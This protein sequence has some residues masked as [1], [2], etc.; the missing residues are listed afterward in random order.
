MK[1]IKAY[2]ISLV[3]IFAMLS[4][5]GQ[6]S[7]SEWTKGITKA[8][9]HY[10]QGKYFQAIRSVKKLHRYQK[11]KGYLPHLIPVTA[12]LKAKYENAYGDAQSAAET[13]E[14]VEEN[15]RLSES[16]ADSSV[17]I[18]ANAYLADVFLSMDYTSKAT[19]YLDKV[20]SLLAASPQPNRLL[21][22]QLRYK[23]LE[24]LITRHDLNEALELYKEVLKEQQAIS[25]REQKIYHPETGENETKKLKKREY[26]TRRALI[27][28]LKAHEAEMYLM[29]GDYLTA[30]SL[31][32]NLEFVINELVKRKHESQVRLTVSKAHVLEYL[33]EYKEA[34]KGYKKGKKKYAG[35]LKTSVPNVFYTA[36]AEREINA[37]LK[38]GKERAAKKAIN[39]FSREHLKRYGRNNTYFLETKR[40]KNKDEIAN[41]NFAK[42]L[43]RAN[44]SVEDFSKFYPNIHAGKIPMLEQYKTL[45][46]KNNNYTLA[47]AVNNQILTILDSLHGDSANIYLENALDLAKLQTYFSYNFKSADS[48][49]NRAFMPI[50]Y[51]NLHPYHEKYMEHMES[52]ATLLIELDRFDSA[53]VIVNKT[54]KIVKAKYGITS[55]EYAKQLKL[56]A[57]IYILKGDFREAEETL[58][59]AVE[60][61][62]DDKA[63]Q[64]YVYY[65]A[66]ITLGDIQQ[67]NGKYGESQNTFKEAMR[68]GKRL[69]LNTDLLAAASSTEMAE[70]LVE[71]GRYKEAEE[72]LSKNIALLTAKHD[73]NYFQLVEP[74]AALG[75]LQLINGNFIEAEKSVSNALRIA[76]LNVSDTGS[77][78]IRNEIL[79]G[80]IYFNMGDYERANNTYRSALDK[81]ISTFGGNHIVTGDILI[82]QASVMLATKV[83][84]DTIVVVLEH[85][86]E[87]I[88]SAV[89]E[90]H[91]KYA[92]AIELQAEVLL[93]NKQYEP[94]LIL[95]EQA[96]AIYVRIYGTYHVRTVENRVRLGNLYFKQKIYP[97]AEENYLLALKAFKKIFGDQHPDYTA[98]L[99]KLG[100]CY[101]ASGD[102]KSAMNTFDVTT[103]IYLEY[104]SKYFPSLTE[105]EKAKY[106]NKI[107]TDFEIFNSL[108]VTYHHEKPKL[109][110][111]MYNYK[112]ATKALL[113]NSSMKVRKQIMASQD[114]GLMNLYN[115]WRVKREQ[116]GASLSLSFDEQDMSGI[117]PGVLEK[118]IA[119]LEK[120]LGERSSAFA[121]NTKTTLY[122][123]KDVKNTLKDNEAA[124]EIIRFHYYENAF[125]D[126]VV[127]AALVVTNETKKNPEL[128]IIPGGNELEEKYFKYYRNVIKYRAKDKYSYAR[129]WQPIEKALNNRSTIYLSADGVYNQLN[130]ETFRKHDNTFLIDKY[131][132]Y[133]VSN[134]K[135]LV[136]K[137]EST[138]QPYLTKTVAIFGNPE[139]GSIH[140]S[141]LEAS[142]TNSNRISSV[143]PLPGAE[144]EV[145]SLR[146]ILNENKWQ[147]QTYLSS[148]ATETEVKTVNNPRVI[149][150]ATHGFFVEEDAIAD[151][152]T[153]SENMPVDNPLL[154]SG[155]LFVGANELLAENN[156]FRVN[157]KEGILTAY[158]AMNLSLDN[159][160]LVVL[161][162]CE[163]GLGEVK[164]GEGVYGLQRS[165][166][167]AGAQNVIM[168]LFK[169][170]DEV[171]QKLMTQFYSEWLATGDK[172]RAFIKAKQKIKEEYENPIFWGSFVMIGLD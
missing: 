118:E 33:E 115:Q 7:H 10:N 116:L 109:L 74:V 141:T 15:W 18:I 80:D 119:I 29:K 66:L 62:K 86:A 160:E 154:K 67:I 1:L 53:L 168:T 75:N 36:L 101:Y 63:K 79:L 94:A 96:Q 52:Y 97:T 95:L 100:R 48:I 111:A 172:R 114:E 65:S 102:Y 58:N 120:Q 47:E 72:L 143:E 32:N 57:E 35:K 127:Y 9:R 130:P 56:L 5:V 78:Y 49:Y 37:Y 156:L 140:D 165:F 139:F 39:R 122:N 6:V 142:N 121:E 55:T 13:L 90:Y 152:A 38:A 144:E 50:V 93:Q 71:T 166:L 107:R 92:R 125:T 14:G 25:Q 159:T 133:S 41:N 81:N 129:F 163:T 113:L 128:V 153:E 131:T 30:D 103:T 132:F 106:W 23:R 91:P 24:V 60:T 138:N 135:D 105:Q 171:T 123:W 21:N 89:G 44:R 68:L 51:E 148:Q 150:I 77:K 59:M 19:F 2:S 170:D 84:T 85:A 134:T 64:T 27:A 40:L 82:K 169:V 8:E 117:Y 61:I 146:K 4:A 164:S 151:A 83:P 73:A 157:K 43:R 155:L 99:S 69:G 88:K 126:S 45:Q 104:I 22:Q 124:I 158:E 46:I 11:K 54:T 108:A 162:A 76:E 161:S 20:D 110:S 26:K 87:I 136:L 12:A 98:T 137:A 70:L 112:L 145:K 42:A 3:F 167:V 34:A 149:H 16:K 28:L 17:R 147:T 31:L